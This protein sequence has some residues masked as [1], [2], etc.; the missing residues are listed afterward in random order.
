M[1]KQITSVASNLVTSL[2]DCAKINPSTTCHVMDCIK[3]LQTFYFG[4]VGPAMKHLEKF[5]MENM[6]KIDR[7]IFESFISIAIMLTYVTL[8]KML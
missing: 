3:N 1:S 6:V 5:I 2:I 4:A 8:I 7:L